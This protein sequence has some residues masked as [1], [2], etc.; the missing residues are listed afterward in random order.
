MKTL[1]KL[2]EKGGETLVETLV[3]ILIITLCMAFLT[4]SAVT[5]SRVNAAASEEY[6][7]TDFSFEGAE[8]TEKTVTVKYGISGSA[9]ITVTEYAKNGL[10]YYE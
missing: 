6:K 2:K 7:K 1:K 5:A 4:T 10:Y 9:D 3:A 8:Q